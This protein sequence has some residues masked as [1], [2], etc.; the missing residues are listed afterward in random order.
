MEEALKPLTQAAKAVRDAR[1]AVACAN[2]ALEAAQ[3]DWQAAVTAWEARVAPA[4][5]PRRR[6]GGSL[7][8]LRR[9]GGAGG[10]VASPSPGPRY[11]ALSPDTSEGA[12]C[13][14]RLPLWIPEQLPAMAGA[15]L[16]G[17]GR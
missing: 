16:A 8:R 10:R 12:L 3:A 11:P 2:Q 15:P 1:T 4:A 9:A 13:D 14:G 5:P 17:V 7:Q 6:R